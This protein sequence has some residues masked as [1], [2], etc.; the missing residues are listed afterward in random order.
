SCG[1]RPVKPFLFL[2]AIIWADSNPAFSLAPRG[3]AWMTI[4]IQASPSLLNRPWKSARQAFE[5]VKTPGCKWGLVQHDGA[6]V[7]VRK[8]ALREVASLLPGLL[9]DA[10]TAPYRRART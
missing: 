1:Q 10:R 9:A 5:P 2:L 7:A 6:E 8:S 3:A 4:V